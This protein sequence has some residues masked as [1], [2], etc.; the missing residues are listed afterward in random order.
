MTAAPVAEDKLVVPEP[1]Q[2]VV[3]DA[4]VSV[5]VDVLRREL[6]GR[7]DSPSMKA[8]LEENN[9]FKQI[10]FGEWKKKEEEQNGEGK[11]DATAGAADG[12][13]TLRK[14]SSYHEGDGAM[15]RDIEYLLPA[16]FGIAAMMVYETQTIGTFSKIFEKNEYNVVVI[17][18]SSILRIVIIVSVNYL[19]FEL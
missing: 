15:T 16:S 19:F 9:S 12:S 14:M 4:I 18:V 17:V 5:P 1:Y 13:V 11:E 6:W 7:Q 10:K 3:A 2:N 8:H